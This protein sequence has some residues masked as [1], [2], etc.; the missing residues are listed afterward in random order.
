MDER[1]R[2]LRTIGSIKKLRFRE[3]LRFQHLFSS[4]ECKE[5]YYWLLIA[6]Q[7]FIGDCNFLLKDLR[8]VN[9]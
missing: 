4:E 8:G 7:D 3:K 6:I 1:A 2:K 9:V 5:G